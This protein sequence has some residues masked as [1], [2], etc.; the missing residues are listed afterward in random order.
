MCWTVKLYV[1]SINPFAYFALTLIQNIS[2]ICRVTHSH[3]FAAL[4]IFALSVCPYE[5]VRQ[6]HKSGKYF[7]Q[8]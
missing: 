7:L 4:V 3:T 1:Y 6:L 5:R 8:I 2:L